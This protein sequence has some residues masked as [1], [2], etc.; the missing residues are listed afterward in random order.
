VLSGEPDPPDWEVPTAEV[1]EAEPT[2]EVRARYAEARELTLP[3]RA[4][5]AP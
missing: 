2:P 1:S 3:R 5:A 4:T